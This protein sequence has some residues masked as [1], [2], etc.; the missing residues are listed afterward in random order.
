MTS[1][2]DSPDLDTRPGSG[3]WSGLDPAGILIAPGMLALA[4]LLMVVVFTLRQQPG[5]ICMTPVFWLA[6]FVVGPGVINFSPSRQAAILRREAA[7]AGAVFGLLVGL[8]F[9]VDTFI[10]GLS[11]PNGISFAVAGGLGCML[12]GAGLC[13]MVSFGMAVLA[14]RRHGL[15]E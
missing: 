1:P 10:I 9:L 2:G 8:I 15:E 6:A 4:W 5:I 13:A 12:F 3:C 7:L 11:D 14:I